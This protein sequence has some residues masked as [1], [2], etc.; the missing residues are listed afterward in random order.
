MCDFTFDEDHCFATT[1]EKPTGVYP[2]AKARLQIIYR[3]GQRFSKY[4]PLLIAEVDSHVTDSR[5]TSSGCGASEDEINQ[6]MTN[7]GLTS[8]QPSHFLAALISFA[9]KSI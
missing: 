8:M 7:L 3:Q 4:R 2:V 6:V 1:I 5:T 9:G